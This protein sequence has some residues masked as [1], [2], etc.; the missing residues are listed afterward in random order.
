[1]EKAFEIFIKA[2]LGAHGSSAFNWM[3][4][5][6]FNIIH[7]QCRGEDVMWRRAYMSPMHGEKGE[8]RDMKKGE[9]VETLSTLDS[10]QTRAGNWVWRCWN[11]RVVKVTIN[12][13][14]SP[15]IGCIYCVQIWFFRWDQFSFPFR[16]RPYSTPIHFSL[17]YF[18]YTFTSLCLS[19]LEL[20]EVGFALFLTPYYFPS[21]DL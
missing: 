11:W 5:S 7:M 18:L 1:M 4:K 13:D 20:F 16:L 8:R 6:P 19:L 17:P 21:S 15:V 2:V 10:P 14:G 12:P 9:S 3:D